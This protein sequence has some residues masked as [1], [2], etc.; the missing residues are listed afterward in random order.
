MD[1]GIQTVYE[2]KTETG[3]AIE[4]TA[5]HP[6]LV[7]Q[8]TNT[9]PLFAF[10]DEVGIFDSGTYSQMGV[11]TLILKKNEIELNQ[12]L[13]NI[14]LETVSKLNQNE[15]TFEFK[16]KYITPNSLPFYHKLLDKMEEYVEDWEFL[17]ILEKRE[18]GRFWTQYLSLVERLVTP[19]SGKFIVLADHLNKPVKATQSLSDF[20]GTGSIVKALQLESQGTMLLQIA[21]VLLG[22]VTYQGSDVY[23]QE[24][25]DRAKEIVA[26]QQKRAGVDPIYAAPRPILAEN[27][28]LSSGK[29]TKV[30]EISKGR[31][32]ATVDGFEKIVS[33]KKTGRKQTYDLQIANTHNFVAQKI[34]AHNTYLQGAGT[35]TGF[36]LRTADSAGANKF[37]VLDNGNVGIGTTGPGTNLEVV[38][39]GSSTEA[40]LFLTSY[41]AT[42]PVPGLVGRGARGTVASP[43]AV[44]AD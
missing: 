35:T 36:S 4:T 8:Q 16:F 44:Q 19:L 21:D 34:V 31:L 25:A 12:K 22:A 24:I 10:V 9:T 6:Y 2:L 1:K 26:A 28:S 29:W 7:K 5:N 13:R 11:G 17:S 39:G 38:G 14:L 40:Q 20:N 42:V 27:T 43:T 23:K 32:I 37:V 41:H 3:K 15:I 30:S 33:I 18:E